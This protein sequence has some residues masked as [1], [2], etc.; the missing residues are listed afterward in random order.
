MKA[1]RYD[2]FH[3]YG[4]NFNGKLVVVD[5]TNDIKNDPKVGTWNAGVTF[6]YVE[7]AKNIVKESGYKVIRELL[8]IPEYVVEVE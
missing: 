5:Y 6:D 7:R 2:E 3:K 8:S 1:I 4:C